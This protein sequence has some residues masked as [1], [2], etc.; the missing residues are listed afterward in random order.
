MSRRTIA[1]I[2]AAVLVGYAHGLLGFAKDFVWA[3]AI[4]DDDSPL[5]PAGYPIP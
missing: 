3:F 4:D 1:L 2:I 5:Y